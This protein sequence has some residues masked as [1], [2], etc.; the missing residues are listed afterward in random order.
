[1]L[2]MA[3]VATAQEPVL[4]L[5]RPDLPL[6][7]QYFA[8]TQGPDRSLYLGA[9][10]AVVRFDGAEWTALPVPSPGP[11]RSM[12]TDRNGRVWVGG[13][14]I[15]GYLDRQPD[16]SD[17]FVAVVFAD[18]DG[19]AVTEF[20]DVW[21]I[22][23]RDDGVWMRTLRD[24]FHVGFDGTP[25]R[26]WHHPGRFGALADVEG[27]LLIQWRGIGLKA[28]RGDTFELVPGGETLAGSL[29]YN[30]LPISPGRT[31]L[32]DRRPQLSWL[33]ATGI[34]PF[35]VADDDALQ[36]AGKALVLDS[37]HVAFGGNSG[38]LYVL[39]T[40]A[41]RFD[42]LRVSQRYI[43][44]LAHDADD[45]LLVVDDQGISRFDWP[46]TW[47]RH[48]VE[49]GVV[50]GARGV[51]VEPDQL[52]VWSSAGVFRS[53][54][55]DGALRQ[56][57]LQRLPWT[58]SEAWAGLRD[59]DD[60]LLAESYELRQINAAGRITAIGGNDL[61][62]R[63]LLASPRTP[64]RL[65]I[66]T[67]HGLAMAERDASGGWQLRGRAKRLDQRI[68]SLVEIGPDRLLAGTARHGLLRAEWQAGPG[69]WD[70]SVVSADVGL[71][72]DRA[73]GA[74]VSQLDEMVVV[75]TE[76]GL[77]RRQGER[78]VPE[79]LA[80]LGAWL[81]PGERVHLRSAVDGVWWAWSDTAVYR[82][83][84]AQ[85]W[86]SVLADPVETGQLDT[87]ALLAD[88]SALVGGSAHLLHFQ[89]PTSAPRATGSSARVT[90]AVLE[91]GGKPP[92]R[93]PL[94]G[95]HILQAPQVS[96]SLTVGS[97]DY[98]PGPPT[99]F[100]T[101]LSGL[102]TH[103][104]EWSRNHRFRF[105]SLPPGDYAFELRSRRGDGVASSGA[106]F[107]LRVVP[108]WHQYTAVRLGA[109]F[110][111]ALLVLALLGRYQRQRMA[112]LAE[113]NRQLDDMVRARTDELEH[114]NRQLLALAELDGLTGVGNR[115]CFDRELDAS[116]VES[117]PDRVC[118]LLLDVDRFK[119]YN[120]LHGHL[121]GD[122]LLRRIATLLQEHM[123]A[124]HRVARYGGEEFAVIA[125]DCDASNGLS[126][127]EGIRERLAEALDG[128][129]VS[130]GVAV[131][132]ANDDADALIAAADHA[133]YRA[134][135]SGRNR[136]E[137]AERGP[138]SPRQPGVPAA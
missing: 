14:G 118:L 111:G 64:G 112:R 121:A 25:L 107:N 94:T 90:S 81:R 6:P 137:P 43:M 30:L 65:W 47:V 53:P 54:L 77:F 44:D 16:G 70:V 56:P 48:G 4:R 129:T 24:L 104:S 101:R 136:V 133:L 31:L 10:D 51:L 55:H 130:I 8:S 75:S 58:V 50:G 127:A 52:W 29:L 63:V 76:A 3:N 125:R 5:L 114:A 15:F 123:P 102:E 93:L 124:H 82:R 62:P 22:A 46:P 33:T 84:P 17:H 99:E 1:L 34:E 83:A 88:G 72:T 67:E 41:A 37:T 103:W 113:R 45:G 86:Q 9:T 100:S 13:Y 19:N 66:G 134:K 40:E 96:L 11:V 69:D 68:T 32:H 21:G 20:A 73:A 36:H 35:M 23:E 80:G 131:S 108:V 92:Q 105:A 87:L 109:A 119:D 49:A 115:R 42:T 57:A 97:T 117:G 2:L 74:H 138:R 89:A 12:H 91:V 60:M 79:P 39:D 122:A 7:P 120:D 132:Q 38:L 98:T 59:G 126:V 71:S 106:S 128:I 95:V 27:E 135:R 18:E 61:Y 78:F 85:P 110:A 28:L 26:H 116:L